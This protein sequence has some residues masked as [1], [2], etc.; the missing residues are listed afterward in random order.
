MCPMHFRPLMN[1][2]TARSP[3]RELAR[4]VPSRER[5][6]CLYILRFNC[7]FDPRPDSE[8]VR[9]FEVTPSFSA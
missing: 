6:F 8:T 1:I 3:R 4:S 9:L 5:L 2:L 7:L